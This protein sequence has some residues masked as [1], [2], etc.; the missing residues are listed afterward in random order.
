MAGNRIGISEAQAHRLIEAGLNAVRVRSQRD[1]N[2][3]FHSGT[4]LALVG[5]KGQVKLAFHKGSEL[6]PLRDIFPWRKGNLLRG[7][8]DINELDK[9]VGKDQEEEAAVY[10]VNY[11]RKNSLVWC[12]TTKGWTQHLVHAKLYQS[13]GRASQGMTRVLNQDRWANICDRKD[14]DQIPYEE[15]E[16]L[17][18]TLF[19]QKA[20]QQKPKAEE[21]KKQA[22]PAEPT[23]KAEAPTKK[24]EAPT[25]KAEAPTKPDKA[26]DLINR[27]LRTK[28]DVQD[29]REMLVLAQSEFE[30]TLA[31]LQ[32]TMGNET[33]QA[34]ST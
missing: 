6:I 4:L 19:A 30:Q 33:A 23:K 28:K 32:R 27:L 26:D 10:Y 15:A 12:G 13:P 29:A 1:A 17:L 24:D 2:G 34:L 20:E 18:G 7:C 22:A 8:K 31:E 5:D 3:H 14:I 9:I 16:E 11:D 21:P 25:K